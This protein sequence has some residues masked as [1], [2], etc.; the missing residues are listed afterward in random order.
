MPFIVQSNWGKWEAGSEVTG[1]E[2]AEHLGCVGKLPGWAS[3]SDDECRKLG[4]EP[5]K[6]PIPTERIEELIKRGIL[7]GIGNDAVMQPDTPV[8]LQPTYAERMVALG[9]FNANP[10]LT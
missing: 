5:G 8:I 1:G 10:R 2:I 9:E 7:R 3:P 4:M 6:H